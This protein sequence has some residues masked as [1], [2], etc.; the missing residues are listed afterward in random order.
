MSKLRLETE[1]AK[2]YHRLLLIEKTKFSGLFRDHEQMKKNLAESKD[3]AT[4]QRG[5]A[6]WWRDMYYKMEQ[7]NRDIRDEHTVTKC[8]LQE[9]EKDLR[10]AMQ[11]LEVTEAELENAD[12]E[13]EHARAEIAHTS[14]VLNETI[15]EPS[16]VR[17]DLD[18]SRQ[19]LEA[20]NIDL[21]NFAAESDLR[22]RTSATESREKHEEELS[23]HIATNQQLRQELAQLQS[24][25]S[26][27]ERQYTEELSRKASTENAL[28]LSIQERTQLKSCAAEQD[29]QSRQEIGALK[30]RVTELEAGSLRLKQDVKSRDEIIAHTNEMLAHEKSRLGD[31]EE[32][33]VQKEKEL[34]DA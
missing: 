13:R 23:K 21:L 28:H 2:E 14:V 27:L 11:S 33:L 4:D 1:S 9:T 8:K 31:R 12:S 6:E 5:I 22:E 24:E 10:E 32:E 25:Y 19:E 16:R 26:G 17:D 15:S 20:A 30:N 34:L 18:E 7:K 3:R 29:V